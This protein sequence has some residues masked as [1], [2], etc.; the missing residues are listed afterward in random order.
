MPQNRRVRGRRDFLRH[1]LFGAA[2]L[3]T[4]YGLA[5]C[6]SRESS[7]A[8]PPPPPAEGEPKNIPSRAVLSAWGEA[9]APLS[10]SGRVF[11]ADGRTPVE[12]L[13]L[14]VYHTDAR[15]HYSELD[16]NGQEPQPRIKGWVRTDGEGRY[17]FRTTR[18]GAYPSRRNPAH[19]H[20]KAY[21]AGRAEQWLQDFLF[22][23]DPLVN[24]E[25]RA[26]YQD[27]GPFSP[28]MKVTR[29]ADGRLRCARD[30]RLEKA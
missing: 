30:I 12:G 3:A 25:T 8:L 9:G 23:D 13:T 15:G 27:A 2:G 14:Y 19:I 17:E 22:D 11:A 18:P 7:A 20:V 1:G 5:G 10:V 21:G 6:G 24:A 16:G 26:R 29:D 28:V 4:L